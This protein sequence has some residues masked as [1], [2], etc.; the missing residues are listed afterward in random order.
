MEVFKYRPSSPV[1]PV[2]LARSRWPLG[3]GRFIL[4]DSCKSGE[5]GA[6]T[7]FQVGIGLDPG[8]GA[9]RGAQRLRDD[10]AEIAARCVRQRHDRRQVSG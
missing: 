8:E 9:S 6:R 4:F 7:S 5:G 3:Q 1:E 10:M 2:G